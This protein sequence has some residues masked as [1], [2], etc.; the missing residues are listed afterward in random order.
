MRE[1]LRQGHRWLCGNDRPSDLDEPVRGCYISGAACN[2]KLTSSR[3]EELAMPEHRVRVECYS[4][5]KADERP[6]KITIA[7]Q[8]EQIVQIEDHWYSP[9]ETFFRVLLENG[10]RYVLRHVEAQDL[11]FIQDFRGGKA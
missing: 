7:Q 8:V 9:G 1:T 10:D 2:A 11:W 6:S 4:G 3:A 5:Y